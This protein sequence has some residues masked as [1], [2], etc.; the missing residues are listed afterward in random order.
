MFRHAAAL[1]FLMALSMPAVADDGALAKLFDR[2][3]KEEFQRHPAYASSQGNHDHDDRLDDL[4]AEARA[5]DRAATEKWSRTV[6]EIDAASLSAAGKIDRSKTP[7]PAAF[8]AAI[9]KQRELLVGEL[10]GH[11]FVEI[12]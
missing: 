4:S 10:R 1:V 3:L 8:Q 7:D 2:Y 9:D 6:G 12:R 5:K 11:T